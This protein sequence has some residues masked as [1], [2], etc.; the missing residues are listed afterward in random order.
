M[1]LAV[2]HQLFT[3]HV[4]FV[5]QKVT[6]GQVYLPLRAH[7]YSCTSTF[8]HYSAFIHPKYHYGNGQLTR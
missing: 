3:V 4:G 6:L 5:V 2:S 8:Q 7:W 1:I